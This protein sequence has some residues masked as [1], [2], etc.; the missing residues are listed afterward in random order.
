M[1][2]PLGGA[3]LQPDSRGPGEAADLHAQACLVEKRLQLGGGDRGPGLA[4]RQRIGTGR[5]G[6]EQPPGRPLAKTE[7]EQQSSPPG[8]DVGRA[9]GEIGVE[10]GVGE[11]HLDGVCAAGPPDAG[12]GPHRAG[13]SV[14]AGDETEEGLLGL[15]PRP[16]HRPHA[17][18]CFAH[19]GQLGAAL[20]L[21]PTVGQGRR[22]HRLD[23]HLPDQRQVREGGIRQR[24]IGEPDANHPAR[25][26]AGRPRARC[27]PGPAA[28]ASPRAGA[29]PPAC[30]HA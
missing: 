6:R 20:D 12:L 10:L 5:P 26:G 21:D 23:V 3:V 28:P 29:A 17:P 7:R 14:A 16:Q 13:R 25:P 19:L 18:G 30:G 4:E 1:A 9:A 2:E 8:H 22:E 24:K 27:R 15:G 11:D